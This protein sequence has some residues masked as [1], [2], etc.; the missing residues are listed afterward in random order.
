MDNH[1]IPQDVTHFQFRLIGD[2]TIKQFAYLATGIVLGW[3][4]FTLP[5]FIIIKLPIAALAALSGAFLAFIP[6]EGRSSDM[7]VL[8]F[9]KALFS[10]NQ[11]LFQKPT[12]VSPIPPEEKEQ[13][14][15][16]KGEDEKEKHPPAE[17]GHKDTH[18]FFQSLPSITQAVQKEESIRQAQDHQEAALKETHEKEPLAI[19]QKPA[20]QPEAIKKEEA[21]VQEALTE[22][23]KEEAHETK[24]TTGAEEAHKKVSELQNQMLELEKQ[25][26]ELEKR[27]LA[28]Q[29]MGKAP[30]GPVFI[31]SNAPQKQ[32]TSHVRKISAQMA[33]ASGAPFNIDTPNL[34]TGII[35]DSRNNVLSNILVEVKD[36][37]NN[38]VRAFKTNN[39]GQ[40]ASA[41]QLLNGVYTLSF[42]DPLGKHA[43]DSVEITTTG[44]IV[45]PI[46]VISVDQRELL[47]KELFGAVQ[48]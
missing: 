36:K 34:I 43:F 48:T 19:T 21:H 29:Q 28:M 44:D 32:E 26:E 31:P 22:A 8:F 39:L 17:S 20:P 5:I 18:V 41:T 46:E 25:K 13:T 15:F 23:K 35:R 42:E 2:M 1:P 4:I 38:P 30:A 47:R 7:M 12:P 6:L 11:Y 24:G 14:T 16:V 3:L 45:A 27:L 40:F 9:F 37:D 33:T 10:P